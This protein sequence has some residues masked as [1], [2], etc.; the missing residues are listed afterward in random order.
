MSDDGYRESW[1]CI[2]ITQDERPCSRTV[3]LRE[4]ALHAG[5]QPLCR[6]HEKALEQQLQELYLGIF[7]VP[8]ADVADLRLAR[9]GEQLTRCAAWL[10]SEGRRCGRRPV[11][12]GPS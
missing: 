5:D 1:R 4:E 7:D 10:D 2:A 6:Q 3:A 9:L 8:P 12:P 11:P